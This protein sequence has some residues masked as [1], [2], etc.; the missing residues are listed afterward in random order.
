MAGNVDAP[1]HKRILKSKT[2]VKTGCK[3]C[4]IRKIKCDEGKPYCKKCVSTGRTCDGYESIFRFAPNQLPKTESETAL[5]LVHAGLPEIAPQDIE[6]LNR[7]F[8][9]KTM[10]DVKLGCGEEAKQLL[11]ASRTDPVIQHAITSLRAL[12][13]DLDATGDGK[14]AITQQAPSY[15]YGL[16]QYNL[17][18]G[19]L[20]SEMSFQNSNKL[21]SA[22][23]CCQ[24]FISIEQLLGNY[25]AMAQHIIRGLMIMH[26][27]RA[28]P[29]LDGNRKLLPA[30][31]DQLPMLDVFIVKLFAAPCNF[32]DAPKAGAPAT[33]AESPDHRTIV[34]DTRRDLTK[35][36]ESVL[37][38]LDEVSHVQTIGNALQLEP[39]RSALLHSLESWRINLDLAQP[40][41]GEHDLEPISASFQRLF[42][43]IMQI[44]L[45]GTLDSSPESRLQLVAEND[46]LQSLA[47]VVGQRVKDY[48]MS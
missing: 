30:C 21:K 7:C 34:P 36:S 20:V 48:R 32:A 29:T 25:D 10:L 40:G 39:K 17:A 38:F 22:L 44:V 37:K 46:K 35:I 12:R 4:R 33:P 47:N 26:E 31:R 19:G 42:Y 41:T 23:L 16:K 9:I 3:T 13:E 8:S 24:I 15:G 45:I 18:L 11:E 1:Q 14:T 2:K 28:R 43:H 6:R 27:S 5:P